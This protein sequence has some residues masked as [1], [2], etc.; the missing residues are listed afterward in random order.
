M[1]KVYATMTTIE[2]RFPNL[3]KNVGELSK[4]CDKVFVKVCGTLDYPEILDELSNVE[5]EATEDM[6]GSEQ[7]FHGFEKVDEEGYMFVCDD[8]IFYS[9]EYCQLMKETIDKYDKECGVSLHNARIDYKNIDSNFYQNRDLVTMYQDL[10]EEFHGNAIF[11]NSAAY[12][13]STFHISPDDCPVSQMDDAYATIELVKRDLEIISP[14]R[15]KS[16]I[17]QLG[18]GGYAIHCAK[19]DAEGHPHGEI[20]NLFNKHK[21]MLVS[22]SEE[23]GLI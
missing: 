9:S 15:D 23:R 21:D 5:V 16:M 8:D 12:H 14:A 11:N 13:T 6:L 3:P 19:G 7:K 10:E 1:S 18:S 2:P 17:D 4:N 22:Y 20:D